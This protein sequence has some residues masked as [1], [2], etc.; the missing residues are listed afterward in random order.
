[1]TKPDIIF[2]KPFLSEKIW[3]GKRLQE[4][5]Y[6]I[7]SDHVGE[8]LIISALDKMSSTIINPSLEGM[9]YLSFYQQNPDFFNHYSKPYPLLTKI[10]DANDKLSVQVHPDDAYAH[11][12]HQSLGKTECWYILDAEPGAQLVYGVKTHNRTASEQLVQQKQWDQLLNYI[13]VKKG[14][15]IFVP[16]GMVHAIGKGILIYELQQSSDITYRLYDYDRLEN[17]KPR[18]LHLE[19]SLNVIKY[20]LTIPSPSNNQVLVDCDLFHLEHIKVDGD[21]TINY[22]QAP[23]VEVTVIDGHGSVQDTSIAKGS[24]FVIRHNTKVQ[25]QGNVELLIAYP[26]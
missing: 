13:P 25:V 14:D 9:D 10:I 4:F 21:Y 26:K 5:N 11:E 19:D 7:A 20:D 16:A 15:F 24:C 12:K 17:N 1:M 8:A 23:W 22:P 18:Q 6:D 3:G 2:L